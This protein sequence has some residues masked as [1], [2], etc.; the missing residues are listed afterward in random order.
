MSQSP[1]TQQLNFKRYPATS[2][3]SLQS[4]SAADEYVFRNLADR[5][6][7]KDTIAVY[8]DR[9]GYYT[10]HLNAFRPF[11]IIDRKSQRKSL[12]NNHAL[13]ALQADTDRWITPLD[14]ISENITVGI[15]SVPKSMDRFRFYLHRLAASL[16][17]DGIIICSF[18][19]KYFTTQMLEIA[20][21]YFED[22]EQSL[23]WKKSRLL[24]LK[25]KKEVPEYDMIQE[26]VFE[27]EDGEKVTLSQY[28]GVFSADHI[29]YATQFLIRTVNI[30][31]DETNILDLGAGNGV[32]AKSI[33]QNH[34]EAN[35]HLV[36]DSWLAVE[37]SR[38][39]LKEEN[40]HFYWDDNLKKIGN[41]S[42]DV[43]LS[44]PPFHFGHET[45]I[46][47]SVK[48]FSQVFE[49]L[50]I[51]GRFLV[52]ANQHLNYKTHLDKIFQSVSVTAEDDK[53]VIY[54]CKKNSA[55]TE[56]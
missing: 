50:K 45:N 22:V 48:L 47:V 21:E 30:T 27:P 41:N 4:W 5:D 20:N 43:A 56:K 23:A 9:F 40:T 13:N 7:S 29:D 34:P 32:I 16:A 52:V 17:D 55:T 39:N 37:S 31:E 53:F 6:L 10:C 3:R 28:P 49:R 24:I 38:L 33:R 15:I 51:G 25:N 8:N 11:V 12:E 46:E 18:M 36:D 14:E 35:I 1:E 19:T 42:L 2:N 54:E 26:I 44:N